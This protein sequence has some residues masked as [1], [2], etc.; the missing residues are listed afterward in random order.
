MNTTSQ[1]PIE[2]FDTTCNDTIINELNTNSNK[3][4]DIYDKSV[5]LFISTSVWFHLQNNGFISEHG[6]SQCDELCF[7]YFINQTTHF[8]IFHEKNSNQKNVVY[9]YPI[10][11]IFTSF[12]NSTVIMTDIDMNKYKYKKY[13]DMNILKYISLKKYQQITFDTNCISLVN[14]LVILIFNKKDF[15]NICIMSERHDGICS[16]DMSIVKSI[17]QV[18][19]CLKDKSLWDEESIDSFIYDNDSMRNSDTAE[20]TIIQYVKYYDCI[21]ENEN[22]TILKLFEYYNN[23]RVNI[24][25]NVFTMKN[26]YSLK[27]CKWIVTEIHKHFLMDDAG[28]IPNK[29]NITIDENIFKFC[30]MSSRMIVNDFYSFYSFDNNI[31]VNISNIHLI[32]IKN[33]DS[34]PSLSFIIPLDGSMNDVT[35]GDLIL[36][37]KNND[38]LSESYDMDIIVLSIE[39]DLTI[40]Y[41]DKIIE[42]K[43]I[44]KSYKQM[45]DGVIF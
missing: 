26:V 15:M 43:D 11:S 24:F 6:G 5:P 40:D 22:E 29:I 1:S 16:N 36:F 17:K 19:Y 14:G 8:S 38:K 20:S 25:L 45:M 33:I 32:N 10:L 37:N 9:E 39:F 3:F 7:K 30:I 31:T 41:K 28:C 18:N 42:L 27:M 12:E 23:G 34:L 13:D 35:T 44:S 2:I 4:Y 21:Q